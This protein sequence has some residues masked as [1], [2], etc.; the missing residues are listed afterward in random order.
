MIRVVTNLEHAAKNIVAVPKRLTKATFIEFEEAADKVRRAMA[1]P[2]KASRSPVKWDSERQRRF[3]MAKL[4]EEDN[5]PYKRTRRYQQGWRVHKETQGYV[6]S[7]PVEYSGFVAGVASG[8]LQDAQHVTS[9]GQSHIHK[10]RWKVLAV[11]LSKVVARLPKRILETF[12]ITA[13]D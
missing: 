6:L 1:V 13:V 7:N 4:S 8:R 2:G 11:T 10:D 9:T 5:L 3:V 12:R